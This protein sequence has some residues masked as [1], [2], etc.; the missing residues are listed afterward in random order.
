MA[1]E[2]GILR[3]LGE[4]AAAADETGDAD[5]ARRV[6]EERGVVHAQAARVVVVGE[7]KRGKSSLINALLRRPGLLPVDSDIATSVHVTVFAAP[8]EQA[9]VVDETH[10]DG[11][12]VSLADVAEYAALDPNTKEMR[13]PGVREVSIGLRDPLLDAGLDLVDTPGVGGLVAG[14][15]ALTLAAL[16]MADALLF[17]VNGSGEL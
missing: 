5:G 1:T 10:Q 3:L 9:L 13:H 2:T 17:V 7:K 16:T 12:P 14:H 8:V 11:F 4:V 6:R 15:A